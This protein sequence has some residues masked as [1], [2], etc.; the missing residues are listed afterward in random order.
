MNNTYSRLFAN[1]LT[2]VFLQHVGYSQDTKYDSLPD[3]GSLRNEHNYIKDIVRYEPRTIIKNKFFY[4]QKVFSLGA[5]LNEI[6]KGVNPG[7]HPFKE[8]TIITNRTYEIENCKI[9]GPSD[10]DVIFGGLS[11]SVISEG[12]VQPLNQNYIFNSDLLV[13]SC[14]SIG[15]YADH[16]TFDKMFEVTNSKFKVIN[17]S[18]CKLAAYIGYDTVSD[19]SMT[20]SK[21]KSYSEYSN[22]YILPFSN[23]TRSS[24]EN[25]SI[26]NYSYTDGIY[27]QHEFTFENDSLFNNVKFERSYQSKSNNDTLTITFINS[28]I[29]ANVIIEKDAKFQRIK[30]DNCSF[31]K[32]GVLLDLACD[33]LTFENCREISPSAV[34]RIQPVT[35][36]SFL[37]FKQSNY[38]QINFQYTDGIILGF[39]STTSGEIKRSVYEGLLEKFRSQNM[40]DSYEKLDLEYKENIEAKSSFTN[41]VLFGMNKLWWNYGYDK[42]RV[43]KWTISL[44]TLFFI[45]NLMFW[46]KI[47]YAYKVIQD[48]PTSIS[49][50]TFINKLKLLGYVFLYTLIIFFS[51]KLDFSKIKYSNLGVVLLL[52]SQYILGLICVLFITSFILKS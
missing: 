32:E 1:I 42:L 45:I 25:C 9:F 17:I 51:F 3:F 11:D 35:K 47:Q 10:L 46:G 24:Y 15:V 2:L 52:F 13:D 5:I 4:S 33:E 39:D 19:I 37:F 36:T 12:S 31:A 21:C 6:R 26:S 48:S 30:F 34:L 16:C 8:D 38:S 29:S 7:N 18:N 14:Y 50:L 49:N 27:K 40:H 22:I 41:R 44:I 28:Y 23:N 43:F 20:D